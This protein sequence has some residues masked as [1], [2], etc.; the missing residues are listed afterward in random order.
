MRTR[1][2]KFIFI[3]ISLCAL[4]T[5]NAWAK[6]VYIDVTKLQFATEVQD[7]DDKQYYNGE[8]YLN[9]L[10]VH[11]GGG[12]FVTVNPNTLQ[13][14][15]DRKIYKVEIPETSTIWQISTK[16]KNSEGSVFY[17][18]TSSL[19]YDDGDTYVNKYIINK[20]AYVANDS[21]VGEVAH[22]IGFV[23]GGLIYFDNSKPIGK[24]LFKW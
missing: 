5:T 3:V 8:Y 20:V 11:Y 6:Y 21:E 15:Y 19:T 24:L 10:R 18:P 23:T 12:S 17:H 13:T 1:L 22:M 14:V 16:R 2:Y 4:A 7:K 9:N